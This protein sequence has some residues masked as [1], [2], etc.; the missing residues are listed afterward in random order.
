MSGALCT[1]SY[2]TVHATDAQGT[3]LEAACLA[4]NSMVATYFL[5]LT[6]GR[7]ASYRPEPLVEELLSVPIPAPKPGLLDGIAT[8]K[9]VDERV[10]AAFGFKDAERVL[11]ED[12]FTYTLGDFKG[13]HNSLGRQP[14]PRIENQES[15]PQLSSYCAYFA[16]VLKAAFGQDK[17]IHATIFQEEKITRACLIDWWLSNG[18]GSSGTSTVRMRLPELLKELEQVVSK[19]HGN[20]TAIEWRASMKP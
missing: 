13:D 4:Y 8:Q 5:F 20:A 6:S 15:E 18:S 9:Q 3:S 11:I 17:A 7:F 16:R 14:T 19:T 2:I 10:F 1:Q 12:L